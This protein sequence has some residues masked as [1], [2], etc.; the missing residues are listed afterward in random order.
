MTEG[1]IHQG[2]IA[3]LKRLGE[4]VCYDHSRTD[5]RTTNRR[6]W[7][8]FVMFAKDT[9][10]LCVEVKKLGGKL[11]PEQVACHEKLRK[12]G[13]PVKIVFSVEEFVHAVAT[14]LGEEKRIYGPAGKPYDPCSKPLD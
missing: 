8:D 7:P 14:W 6:G 4:I 10:V 5:K 9:P 13:C 12:V 1:E 2:C 3:Y 11:R